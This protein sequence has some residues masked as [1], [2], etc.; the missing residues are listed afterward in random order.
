M[1][2]S[3]LRRPLALAAAALLAASVALTGCGRQAVNPLAPEEPAPGAEMPGLEPEEP[4]AEEPSYPMPPGNP[5]GYVPAPR[6]A[7]PVAPGKPAP[8]RP[9]LRPLPKP[10][11]TPAA[12]RPAAPPAADPAAD[13]AAFIELL[14]QF[15]YDPGAR[16]TQNIR[17]QLAVVHRVPQARFRWVNSPSL[18]LTYG[19]RVK[20]FPKP[21]SYDQWKAEGLELARRTA[22]IGYYVARRSLYRDILRDRY[23]DTGTDA[24]LVFY[25]RL[26]G[27]PLFVSYRADGQ[28]DDYGYFR[29][30][31]WR[32]FLP[33]PGSIWR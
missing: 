2:C 25:K 29:V 32:N 15:G 30:V 21:I 23:N 31:D 8:S 5:G 24:E 17:M 28:L 16:D 1:S 9:S 22:G 3:P 13:M 33:V 6:P 18:G 14:G 11:A 20:D 26:E 7:T 4:G 27:T 12:K 10:T 19:Q